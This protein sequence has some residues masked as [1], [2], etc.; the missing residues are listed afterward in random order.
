MAEL[1][2]CWGI[3]VKLGPI[4]AVVFVAG[5]IGL[6]LYFVQKLGY[7]MEPLY[8]HNEFVSA[9]HAVE[10][11]GSP[12]AEERERFLRNFSIVADRASEALEQESPETSA[13]GIAL[14]LTQRRAEREREIDA[15]IEA[16]GCE[17]MELWRLV[18]LHEA[19]AR[20]NLG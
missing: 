15:L 3:I 6:E 1:L 11:C 7:R 9:N 17:D 10:R 4:L 8:I 13:Q 20:L 12:A 2:G 14:A 5:Y 19:R 18:K 16:K